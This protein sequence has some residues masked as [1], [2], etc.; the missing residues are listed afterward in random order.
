MTTDDIAHSLEKI[1]KLL[2]ALVR[3]RYAELK[4]KAFANENEEKVFEFT[5]VKGRDEICKELK[6][7]P[8]TLSELWS[9]WLELGLLVKQGNSYKKTL[10]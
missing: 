10:D 9:R 2:E 1:E 5:G 3:F 6:I 4:D 8:N 7:S